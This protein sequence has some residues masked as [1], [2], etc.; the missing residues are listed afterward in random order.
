MTTVKNKICVYIHSKIESL[1]FRRWWSIRILYFVMFVNVFTTSSMFTNIYPYLKSLSEDTTDMFYSSTVAAYPFGMFLSSPLLGYWFNRSSTRQPLVLA[2]SIVFLSCASYAY[3]NRLP[4]NVAIW[5]VLVSRFMMGVASGSRSVISAY[6][7]VATTVEE[8]SDTMTNLY[9]TIPL[10]FTIG[11]LVGVMFEPLGTEGFTIPLIGLSINIYT[12][13]IIVCA[14]LSVFNLVIIIWFKEFFVTPVTTRNT[15]THTSESLGY[16]ELIS[17]SNSSHTQNR[18]YDR[19]GFISLAFTSFCSYL[20]VAATDSFMTPLS[21]DEFAWT[22]VQAITYNNILIS[23]GYFFSLFSMYLFNSLLKYAEERL[24]FLVVIMLISLALFIYIP[25]P[26]D[27]PELAHSPYNLTTELVGCNYVTKPWCL[28]VPKLHL[29]QYIIATL[30]YCVILPIICSASNTIA[31]KVIGPHP[32]GVLMGILTASLAIGRCIEP[33]VFMSL[34]T[35]YGPQIT[36]AAMDWVV[37]TMILVTL[38][39]YRH[40]VPYSYTEY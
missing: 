35:N 39:T 36:Y 37:I 9:M 10:A 18:P 38:V 33:I 11:P 22:S 28:W 7:T 27:L 31:S 13:P 5:V 20:L 34:Y 23:V 21:M 8:R 3:S 26:G 15:N 30:M 2:L 24:L 16:T 29:F 14:L 17:D 25:W 1:K 19:I 4:G 12:S 6:I 32:P 40:L